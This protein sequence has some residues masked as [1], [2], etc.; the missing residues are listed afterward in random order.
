MNSLSRA[1][2]PAHA[3]AERKLPAWALTRRPPSARPLVGSTMPTTSRRCSS[4]RTPAARSNSFNLPRTEHDNGQVTP[5]LPS[6]LLACNGH[7]ASGLNRT[8]PCRAQKPERYRPTVLVGSA[9][10]S[11]P[12]SHRR[13]AD[14]GA[15]PMRGPRRAP[16]KQ[17]PSTS[18][19]DS[20]DRPWLAEG[21]P[22]RTR[23]PY[24]VKLI[25]RRRA[26][27]LRPNLC[28]L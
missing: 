22:H 28:R 27:Y 26:L 25:D 12:A 9:L 23:A 18:A 17:A 19:D 4:M 21:C 20:L 16:A 11:K 24:P 3:T 2:D 15:S 7:I 14:R 6:P 1:L 13:R 10:L 8:L 5:P